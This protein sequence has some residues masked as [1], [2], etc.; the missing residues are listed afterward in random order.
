M[1]ALLTL[2]AV[3][4][5]AAFAAPALADDPASGYVRPDDRAGIR[6]PGGSTASPAASFGVRPDDRAGIRGIGVVNA[7]VGT[8]VVVRVSRPG[9]DWGDAGIGAASGGGL[10]L[11]LLGASRLVRRAHTEPRPA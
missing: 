11:L 8:P 1:K 7:P 10:V 6:G 4:G 5:T 9:F 3:L 2:I